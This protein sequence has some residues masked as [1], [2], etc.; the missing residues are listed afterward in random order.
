M[1]GSWMQKYYYRGSRNSDMEKAE[2][3]ASRIV[4]PVK[5]A[6]IAAAALYGTWWL[7]GGDLVP[8]LIIAVTIVTVLAI[9]YEPKRFV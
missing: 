8:V 6:F 7:S 9:Y 3:N 5:A 1:P 2:L 4:A